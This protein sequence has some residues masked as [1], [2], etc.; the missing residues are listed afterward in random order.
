LQGPLRHCLQQLLQ[1]IVHGNNNKRK[2]LTPLGAM[3]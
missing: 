1:L 2:Q 3:Q